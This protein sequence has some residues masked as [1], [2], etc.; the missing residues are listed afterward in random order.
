MKARFGSVVPLCLFV[1]GFGL[2]ASPAALAQNQSSQVTGPS[3]YLY[4]TNEI[5]KPGMSAAHAKNEHAAAEAMRQANAP[6]HYF[7]LRDITGPSHVMFLHGFDS[8]ADLAKSHMAMVSNATL[9]AT[10]ASNDATDGTF[11][12]G[13]TNSI[14]KYRKDLSLNP[15]VDFPQMRLFEITLYHVRAGHGQDFESLAKVFAKAYESMPNERWAVFEKMYG[16]GSDNIFILATPMKSANEIDKEQLDS[17]KLP[18]SIGKAQMQMMQ[19][20]Y[21]RTV[22]SSES[23]LFAISP[24]MSYEPASWATASPDF[25]GKK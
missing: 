10:L 7:A 9:E 4:L 13:K 19:E 25:W 22:K 12:T 24:Q 18:A 3:A 5:E 20:L 14:Y 2:S 21:N 11:L 23:D 6:F 16:V 17:K 15:G 1:A 8:F